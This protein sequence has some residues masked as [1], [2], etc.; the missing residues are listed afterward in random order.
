MVQGGEYCSVKQLI[1]ESEAPLV[2][3]FL[4]SR[5]MRQLSSSY[6]ANLYFWSSFLLPKV[7]DLPMATQSKAA[8]SGLG[9]AA[10]QSSDFRSFL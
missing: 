10:L 2:P 5:L 1:K 8:A 3:A 9:D 7:H 4:W 6:L